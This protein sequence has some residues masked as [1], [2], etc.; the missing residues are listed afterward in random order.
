MK[1]ITVILLLFMTGCAGHATG[2][3]K[4]VKGYSHL[5]SK[6]YQMINI[7]K[8][9]NETTSCGEEKL[10]KCL[11]VREKTCHKIYRAAAVDCFALFYQRKGTKADVCAPDN[12][13][14]IDGCMIKN[15]L[16]YGRGGIR[17]AMRCM[18]AT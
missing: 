13:G 9:D 4:Y 5:D 10:L 15:V 7:K 16:K 17:Q 18:K 14:F 1:Y 6:R 11:N 12:K 8:F 2:T 3:R